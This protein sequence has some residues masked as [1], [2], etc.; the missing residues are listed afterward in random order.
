ML[1]RR[2]I[3]QSLHAELQKSPSGIQGLDEITD[4]GLPKG[5]VSLVVGKAG[6]GKTL[7]GMEFLLRG[8]LEYHEPGV[9]ISFEETERDLVQNFA[10]LGYDLTALMEKN[11][12]AID[13][14]DVT[15]ND[16][17]ETGEFDLEGLFIRLNH[18]IDSIG[19]KR[20]V[21]DTIESL[22]SG[23]TNAGI[24]RA[25]LRRLF[26]W[27][28]EKGVTA[29]VTGESG[30]G[31]LTRHGLEEYISDCVIVLD[32][33]VEDQIS[34][35]RLRVVKYR[36]STHG[37]NEYP[38]LIDEGGISVLPIT[39]VG[40]AYTV[41]KDRVSS[42]IERLDTMLE[43]RGF[44]RGS[45]ILLAGTPGTGKTSFAAA[46]ADAACRRGERCLFFSFEESPDQII[47]NVLSIGIDLTP[48]LE[49]GLLRIH[50]SRPTLFGLEMHLVLMLKEIR[51][52]RP[53]AVIVDPLSDLIAVGST[54]DVKMMLVRL[55]DHLKMQQITAFFTHLIHTREALQ[56]SDLAVSSIIDTL[57]HLRDIE[58]GG[59]HNRGMFILKSRGMAYSNQIRE[60][61]IT[62]GGIIIEDTC[63]G[64]PG[65]TVLDRARYEPDVRRERIGTRE[66]ES[67]GTPIAPREAGVQRQI[68]PDRRIGS[69]GKTDAGDDRNAHTGGDAMEKGR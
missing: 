23:L 54:K 3:G 55:V 65:G 2:K 22:F 46:F 45:T 35:R 40:L 50:S 4:G 42:G 63:P 48:H 10:S 19:A 12:I 33:R 24:L 5:R 60:Y 18:A 38:F 7:L 61:R 16:I 1:Q 49:S 57:I 67:M 8:A 53:Q 47:R 69:T 56:P 11:Q 20:V 37:T 15:R 52:V 32:H 27:L 13:H 39:S 41:T 17:I 26:F 62:D 58:C 29:I 51:E 28:K 66:R 14:M 30:E 9:F 6:S 59:E 36:G 21:L 44:Y 68:L 25:E 34:T 31:A 43:G 64:G